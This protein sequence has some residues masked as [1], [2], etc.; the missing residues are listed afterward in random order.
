MAGTVGDIVQLTLFQNYASQVMLN[1]FYYRVEDVPTPGYLEG[2]VS[3]FQTWVMPEISRCQNGGVNYTKI[4]AQNIFNFDIFVDTTVTP[5]TGVKAPA[6]DQTATFI[7]AGIYL[8]PGNRRV[9]RGYKFISGMHEGD[10][11]GNV[12]TTTY[13]GLL[14]DVA[15]EMTRTLSP[16]VGTD[17]FRQVLVKRVLVGGVYKLPDNQLSMGDNWAYV[18]GAIPSPYITTMRSRK[19]DT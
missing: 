16:G 10:L 5:P 12:F 3:E 1:V 17:S 15:T 13:L 18:V 14:N 7:A 4:V 11:N 8:Q 19:V 9:R 6:G 2:L